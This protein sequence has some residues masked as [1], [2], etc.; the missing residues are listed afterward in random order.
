MEAAR[1]VSLLRRVRHDYANHLQVI[2]GYLELGWEEQLRSYIKEIIAQINQERIIF[3]SLAAQ[4]ALYFYEQLLTIRDMGIIIVYED[5]DVKSSTYLKEHNEPATS[6]AILQS[7]SPP[8]EDETVVYLS[9][10]E[11]ETEIEMFFNCDIWGEESRR[12]QIDK[13]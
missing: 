11:N 9:I 3:E 4:D 6:I 10:H 12:I 1:M 13:R 7:D 8:Q 2:G 5:L